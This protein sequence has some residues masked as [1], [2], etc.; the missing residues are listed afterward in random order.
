MKDFDGEVFAAAAGLVGRGRR[1]PGKTALCE[2]GARGEEGIVIGSGEVE[3]D[4]CAIFGFWL[5]GGD[6]G[7]LFSRRIIEVGMWC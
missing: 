3:R 1:R 4:E 2:R 6:V 7:S 5:D